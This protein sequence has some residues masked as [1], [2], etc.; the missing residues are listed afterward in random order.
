RLLAGPLSVMIEGERYDLAEQN[1]VMDC[2]ECGSCAY[3]CPSKRP[4]VQHFRRAKAEI[5]AIRHA[6]KK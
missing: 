2:M 6:A 1:F 3:V 5:N 4:L